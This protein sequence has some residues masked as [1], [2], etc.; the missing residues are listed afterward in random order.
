MS[1]SNVLIFLS[2][3]ELL[4]RLKINWRLPPVDIS[5]DQKPALFNLPIDYHIKIGFS[6]TILLACYNIYSLLDC[7]YSKKW[8]IVY[9]AFVCGEGIVTI[10]RVVRS[11]CHCPEKEEV[12]PGY[13]NITP[14][15]CR[16]HKQ[17]M[18]YK[19]GTV[20]ELIKRRK[21]KK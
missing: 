11:T 1:L 2:F 14:R 8:Y 5:F 10:P 9:A 3:G 6:S 17:G 13:V 7:S 12:Y 16:N 15:F 20:Q 19:K 18:H 4:G 21:A